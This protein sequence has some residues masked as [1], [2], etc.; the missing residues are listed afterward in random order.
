M[1]PLDWI[2]AIEKTIAQQLPLFGHP[3]AFPWEKWNLELSKALDT[4]CTIDPQTSSWRPQ[5]NILSGLGDQPLLIALSLAPL[6]GQIYLA[7]SAQDLDLLTKATLSVEPLP[8][9]FAQR[10]LQ[11]E[12]FNL[13]ALKA[14]ECFNT[15]RPLNDLSAHLESQEPLAIDGALCI[16]LRIQLT[17]QTLWGRLIIPETFRSQF[18]AHFFEHPPSILHAP[19]AKTLELSVHAQI[20][21]TLLSKKEWSCVRS[22]DLVILDKCSFDPSTRKGMATLVLYNTPLFHIKIREDRIKILDYA[23]YYE[24]SMSDSPEIPETPPTESWEEEPSENGHLWSAPPSQ[25]ENPTSAAL[26]H[27]N[28]PLPITVEIA[29]LHISLDKLLELSPGNVLELGVHPEQGVYLTTSGK[30]IAHGELVKIGEVLG[31]R[32]LSLL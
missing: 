30:R 13:L 24:A 5:E 7:L 21:H 11:E 17:T 4:P 31:V 26:A 25:E 16:E 2:Q 10:K 32:I 20:G 19:L 12:F 22:G 23:L 29:K 1:K 15:L 8:K 14:I 9:G 3:P 27:Q 28:I 6:K 18:K